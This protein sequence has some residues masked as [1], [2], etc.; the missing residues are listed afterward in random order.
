RPPDDGSDHELRACGPELEDARKLGSEP[1]GQ[2]GA[3]PVEQL[4]RRDLLKGVLAEKRDRALLRKALPELVSCAQREVEAS[5]RAPKRKEDY[6]GQRG[7]HDDGTD[8]CCGPLSRDER[9]GDDPGHRPHEEG[10]RGRAPLHEPPHSLSLSAGLPPVIR[11]WLRNTAA[12]Y[13]L[14]AEPLQHRLVA[15]P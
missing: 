11:K 8:V 12:N 3:G 9:Y 15:A 13:G 5:R 10:R 1:S 14:E 6:A 7:E 2:R 4:L